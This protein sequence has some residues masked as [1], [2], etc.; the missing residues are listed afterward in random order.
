MQRPEKMNE[1]VDI[2]SAASHENRRL[3]SEEAKQLDRLLQ[4]RLPNYEENVRTP[5][6]RFPTVAG[7]QL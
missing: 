4:D 2:M 5:G 3:T 1:V 6:H 7:P